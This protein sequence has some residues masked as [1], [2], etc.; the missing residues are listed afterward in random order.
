VVAST[1]YKYPGNSVIGLAI[2]LA[3]VPVYFLWRK[4]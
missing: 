1:I 4:S 3:G 2:M